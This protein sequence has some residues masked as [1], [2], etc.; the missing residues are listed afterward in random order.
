MLASSLVLVAMIT[1]H[2]KSRQWSSR[3]D[4]PAIKIG[5]SPSYA[6]SAENHPHKEDATMTSRPHT[7][8]VQGCLHFDLEDLRKATN[9]FDTRPVR[10]GGCKLG[11]GGF[12]PVYRGTLKHTEVAIKS[13]RIV[14]KV[15]Q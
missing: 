3:E 2:W 12:G 15:R 13:L 6:E 5:T 7:G 8:Y 4:A 10:Q 9:N 1:L 14:P 11:E